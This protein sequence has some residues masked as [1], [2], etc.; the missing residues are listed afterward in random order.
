MSLLGHR[1]WSNRTELYR[2]PGNTYDFSPFNQSIEDMM[3]NAMYGMRI[4][5]SLSHKRAV[6][7]A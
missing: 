5:R 1:S 2:Y 4:I 3:Y 6:L 7:T